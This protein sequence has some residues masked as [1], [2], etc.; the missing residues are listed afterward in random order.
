MHVYGPQKYFVVPCLPDSLSLF[1]HYFMKAMSKVLFF[2]ITQKFVQLT[3]EQPYFSYEVIF[4]VVILLSDITYVNH[5]QII[6]YMNL[7]SG[8]LK[9]KNTFP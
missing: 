6:A 4:N 9:Q 1:L 7:T 2:H 8:A 3:A 5:S